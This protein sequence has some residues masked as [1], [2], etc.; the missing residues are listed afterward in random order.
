MKYRTFAFCLLFKPSSLSY[1][2]TFFVPLSTKYLQSI[3]KNALTAF[4]FQQI[5][6]SCCHI[7]LLSNNSKHQI[8]YFLKYFSLV[9]W[10]IYLKLVALIEILCT[11]FVLYLY[12]VFKYYLLDIEK[13]LKRIVLK[14]AFASKTNWTSN[15][16]VVLLCTG[17]SLSVDKSLKSFEI[18]AHIFRS[19]G[20]FGIENSTT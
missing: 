10:D 15:R 20:Y 8:F 13:I 3:S 11:F 14:I 18:R 1:R 19:Q 16:K 5:S 9:L 7:Y 17:L 6:T 4:V 2:L 12:V